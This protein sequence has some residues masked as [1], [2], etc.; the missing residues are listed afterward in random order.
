MNVV[1]QAPAHL[2]KTILPPQSLS[3]PV[4][5]VHS[6]SPRNSCVVQLGHDISA[7]D[8]HLANMT[9]I[10]PP[11]KLFTKASQRRPGHRHAIPAPTRNL[12]VVVFGEFC[13]TFMFLLLS[14]IGAQTAIVTNDP[15]DPS[16]PLLPYSLMY[17][18]ASFGTALAVNVWIF[19]RVTGGMFNPAV[20]KS[21]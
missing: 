12:F 13:G 1:H 2:L 19:Y 16:A 17:I 14:F 9:G 21:S 15:L 3:R 6:S 7:V 8:S 5:F 4:A 11:Q 20:R 10:P 18:A